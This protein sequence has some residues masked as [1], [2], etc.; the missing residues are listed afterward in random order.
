MNELGRLMVVAGLTL[1]AVGL[2]LWSG[3]GRGWLGR[4]PGDIHYRG[5]HFS[6]HFPVVTCL[7]LSV[8]LTVLLW[9][10]RK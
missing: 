3:A 9:W 1:A 2:L 10:F 7:L 4:L 8:I 5:D 6:F